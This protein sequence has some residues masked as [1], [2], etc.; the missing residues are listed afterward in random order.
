VEVKEAAAE[1]AF[2]IT[3]KSAPIVITADVASPK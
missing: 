3:D 1:L 2:S